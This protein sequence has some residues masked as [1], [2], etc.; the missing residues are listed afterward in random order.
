MF[1]A[2]PTGFGKSLTFQILPSV[3]KALFYPGFDMPSL[4]V[5][6]VVSPLRSIV[7]DLVTY[8]RSHGTKVLNQI[9]IFLR[10]RLNVTFYMEVQSH[11][12]GT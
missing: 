5:V 12:L 4:P 2:L 1:A 9:T 3:C 7:K 6:I 11:L 8:L 10:A